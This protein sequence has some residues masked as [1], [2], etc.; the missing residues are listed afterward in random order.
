MHCELVNMRSIKSTLFASRFLMRE[1]AEKARLVKSGESPH[2]TRS[3]TKIEI[4]LQET[5]RGADC[6]CRVPIVDPAEKMH[7]WVQFFFPISNS[8]VFLYPSEGIRV[9]ILK[10]FDSDED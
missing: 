4:I 1:P 5:F 10:G 3:V 7:C 8:F 9:L 2:A 6:R